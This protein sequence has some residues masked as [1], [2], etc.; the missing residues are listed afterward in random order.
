MTTRLRQLIRLVMVGKL[1]TGGNPAAPR[2]ARL[3]TYACDR[4]R[5]IVGPMREHEIAI[6]IDALRPYCTDLSEEDLLHAAERFLDYLD[7]TVDFYERHYSNSTLTE[8]TS[9]GTVEETSS[10]LEQTN[11]PYP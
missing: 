4:L 2:V 7:L 5:P 1:A 10:T 6:L 11:I 3:P 9:R 8:G